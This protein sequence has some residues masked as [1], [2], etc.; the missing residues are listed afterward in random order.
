MS[1]RWPGLMFGIL[2]FAANQ[3][4]TPR[5]WT[6]FLQIDGRLCVRVRGCL[7]IPGS[8]RFAPIRRIE[9]PR[10]ARG[11]GS[12]HPPR[13]PP[14]PLVPGFTATTWPVKMSLAVRQ[15]VSF[16]TIAPSLASAFNR[17]TRVVPLTNSQILPSIHKEIGAAAPSRSR[18]VSESR[19]SRRSSECPR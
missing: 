5:P 6:T 17:N 13:R 7:V 1:A 16:W 2:I 8:D 4:C 18:T 9:P 14:A 11:H 15:P 10:T 3:F 12:A 19:V